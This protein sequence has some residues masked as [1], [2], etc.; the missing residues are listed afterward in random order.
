MAR[1]AECLSSKCEVPHSN[2]SATKKKAKK[3]KLHMC[4]HTHSIKYY[5]TFEKK[6]ILSF[7]K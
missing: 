7:D 4:V 1:W 2:P 5:L 3:I 6:E